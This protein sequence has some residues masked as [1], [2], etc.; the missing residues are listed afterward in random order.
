MS[1]QQANGS[2]ECASSVVLESVRPRCLLADLGRARIVDPDGV[3]PTTAT[4]SSQIEFEDES[5]REGRVVTLP[6]PEECVIYR[7]SLSILTPPRT[8]LLG[9]RTDSP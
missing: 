3:P 2:Y 7:G 1:L 4:M 5:T 8:A 9:L 6:H